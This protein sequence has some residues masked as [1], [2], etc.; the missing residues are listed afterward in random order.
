MSDHISQQQIERYRQ[1]IMSP[2]ELIAAFDHISLCKACREQMGDAEPLQNAFVALGPDLEAAAIAEPAHLLPD[3]MTAYADATAS[4]VDREIVESH[5]EF[6][7]QCKAEMVELRELKTA[8]SSGR[9]KESQPAPSST[10]W[11]RFLL[12]WHSPARLASLQIATSAAVLLVLVF[13]FLLRRQVA[14]LSGQVN[15]L[16]SENT[17]LRDRLA[18][19]PA[20]EEKLARLEQ[21][22]SR[23][24]SLSSETV[25]AIRDGDELVT[26]DKRGDL[27]GL[28]PL[29][30]SFERLVKA[31]LTEGRAKTPPSIA[32]IIGKPGVLMGGGSQQ[33]AFSLLTPVGT[34]VQTD[35]PT[36]RWTSLSGAESYA[37]TLYDSASGQ[38]LAS[39]PVSTTEWTVSRALNRG[40]IYSWEVV[41]IKEGKEIAVPAP[42]APQA[43]FKVM[44]RSKLEE[45]ERA[46]NTYRSSH[47]VLGLIYAQAGCLDDAERELK[48]VV[49]ANPD[50]PVAEKLLR[51]VKSLRGR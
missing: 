21:V 23:I 45:L 37:V 17:A 29:S 33:N 20:L 40:G 11:S 2:S 8:L 48:A 35:R 44:E 22:Q 5:L 43:R 39:G 27:H 7:E 51:S 15:E 4:D 24:L 46:R 13:T 3:Q 41:A 1:A 26:L 28:K 6:C 38:A 12:F 10:L 30:P 34:V 18:A 25:V 31:A 19:V 14:D 16:Q 36:L 42:P 9:F 50:S 49:D 32:E 47:L